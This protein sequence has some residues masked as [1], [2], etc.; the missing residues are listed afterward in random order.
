MVKYQEK[1]NGM[2][3][4][5]LQEE[6][7]NYTREITSPTDM[8]MSSAAAGNHAQEKEGERRSPKDSSIH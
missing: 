5:Q 8:P 1:V 4:E 3:S 6:W 7:E 2:T